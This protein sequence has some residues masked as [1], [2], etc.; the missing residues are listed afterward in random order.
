MEGGSITPAAATAVGPTRWL[1]QRAA[2]LRFEDLP[3][4]VV[5]WARHC[6]LD[7]LGVTVPGAFEPLADIVLALV[8]EEGGNAQAT[9]VARGRRATLPQAALFNGAASHALDYDDVNLNMIGHPTVPVVSALLPLAESLRLDGRRFIAAVVA[10]YET[11]CRVGRAVLPDHYARGWHS[12]ATNGTLAAAAAC[13]NALGLDV[14]RTEMALGIACAQAA[15]L[16]SMFGSM[17]KPLHVGKSAANGLLAA[18]LAQRG[19]TAATAAIETSQGY[20]D[21]YTRTFD[22]DRITAEPDRWFIRENLFKYHAACYLTHSA[23]EAARAAVKGIDPARIERATLRVPSGNLRVCNILSPGTGLETKFS[24]RHTVALGLT[25]R[26]TAGLDSYTDDLACNP[27]LVRL[28]EKVGIVADDALPLAGARID[29]V[30]AGG[31]ARDATIDVGVPSRDLPDQWVR[32]TGKFAS[33]VTP[34]LGAARATAAT[35][36]VAALETRA[37]VSALAAALA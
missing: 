26:D 11:E 21:T 34:H 10:G 20:A 4:D 15:G 14:D 1:A 19:F 22:A 12:T 37:D 9:L 18:R 24:L 29:L 17:T 27:A 8:D 30:L 7:G 13:A 3:A 35:D 25:G 32:L 6:I 36:I 31:A 23:I 5:E 2:T 28:R 16:K 33:L